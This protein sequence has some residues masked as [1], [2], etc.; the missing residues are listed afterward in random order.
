MTGPN[1]DSTDEQD[2]DDE[3]IVRFAGH[4]PVDLLLTAAAGCG[5]TEALARRTAELIRAGHV[6]SHQRILA[7]TFSNK[8]RDNL[9]CRIRR[10]L[11]IR[12]RGLVSVQNFHGIAWRIVS[13]HGAVI[14]LDVSELARPT[15][16]D[17][18]ERQDRAGINWGNRTEVETLLRVAKGRRQSD[19]EVLGEIEASG[20]RVA[21]A[22]EKC[23]RAEGR[24]D[25]DDLLRHAGRILQDRNVAFG[26]QQ[27][28]AAVIVDEVQ[29]L[30][31]TQLQMVQLLGGTRVTYSGD[32]GQGIYSFAGAEPGAVFADLESRAVEKIVLTRSFRSSPA[33]L[34][35][36]NALAELQGRPALRCA[37]PSAWDE[38]ARFS[39]EAF[40]TLRGEAAFIA[41]H[42]APLLTPGLTVGVLARSGPRLGVL[43]AALDELGIPFTDWS[44]PLSDARVLMDLRRECAAAVATAS[45]GHGDPVALLEQR[46]QDLR[47]ENDLEGRDAVGEACA[48]LRDLMDK[49]SISLV[50]ALARCR[51]AKPTDAPVGQGLH[52]LNAHLGKGQEFDHVVVVGLEEGILPDFRAVD[53][54]QALAEEL[55]ALTVMVSRARCSLLVTRSDDVPSSRG[56]SWIREPSR[57]WTVLQAAALI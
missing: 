12:D 34:A 17:H 57:W 31:V 1:A 33:V 7:A 20:D 41:E 14:G 21:L 37:D 11:T 22:Y 26:Y 44:A 19:D 10:H 13:A 47:G 28:F 39:A 32:A 30:S 53:N 4:G 8:A 25:F 46:C 16:R 5:K 48:A 52:L 35:A 50:A 40:T 9:S 27:H 51:A 18:R 38:S 43:R 29:D 15:K 2:P 42:V 3:A 36:V 6:R 54:S 45:K 55:R 23:L 24:L 49:H 56:G